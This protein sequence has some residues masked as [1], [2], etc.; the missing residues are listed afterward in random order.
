MADNRMYLHCRGCGAELMLA[1]M[2]SNDW[3]NVMSPEEKGREL[4]D[5]IEEHQHCCEGLEEDTCGINPF[6]PDFEPF[7]LTYENRDDW[8]HMNERLQLRDKELHPEK[9]K[10]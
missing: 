7:M 1:K 10:D 9:Y 3:H 8:P 4:F 5:F 2:Y 6:H